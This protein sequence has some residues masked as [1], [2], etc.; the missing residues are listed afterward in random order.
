[1]NLLG[2]SVHIIVSEPFEW[3]EGD[4]FG[5]IQ[6]YQDNKLLVKLNRSIRGTKIISDL[7]ELRPRYEKETFKLLAY[8]PVTING[9]LI[10]E[11]SKSFDFIIIG[12]LNLE[13]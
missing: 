2:K 11:N 9:A 13:N 10:R 8:H 3:Q 12:S 7:I 4:L 6:S 5:V 1:M